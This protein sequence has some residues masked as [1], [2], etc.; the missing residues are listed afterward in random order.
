MGTRLLS[1]A[2]NGRS[3]SPPEVKYHLTNS[4]DWSGLNLAGLDLRGIPLR[5]DARVDATSFAG[6]DMRNWHVARTSSFF[7]L[8]MW[9]ANL[10][11]ADLTGT[12][13]EVLREMCHGGSTYR[14][15]PLLD[16]AAK[17]GMD[18]DEFAVLVWLG[19]VEGRQNKTLEIATNSGEF[20]VH[21]PAWSLRHLQ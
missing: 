18:A 6:A 11:D 1:M 3:A 5:E 10:T 12:S 19:E 20:G 17:V 15:F 21:I 16:A 4:Q 2:E 8:G 9:S 14:S 13:G 7:Q